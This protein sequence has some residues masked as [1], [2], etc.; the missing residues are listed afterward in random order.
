MRRRK[1]VQDIESRAVDIKMKAAAKYPQ[2]EDVLDGCCSSM[3]DRSG[4]SREG[5]SEDARSFRSLRFQDVPGSGNDGERIMS[6]EREQKISLNGPRYRPDALAELQDI[7]DARR[8]G[9]SEMVKVCREYPA[10]PHV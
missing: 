10:G 7:R 2:G 5:G 9:C 1:L 3:A 4:F 6:K 8:K